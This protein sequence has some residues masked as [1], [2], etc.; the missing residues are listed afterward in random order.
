MNIHG[1]DINIE[2]PKG[3]RR[4]GI[5]A[6]GKRWTGPALPCAYGEI[7]GT[8]AKDGDRVDAY[9]G[10]DRSSRKVFVIDQLKADTGK[11]DEAKVMLGFPSKAAALAD[12]RKSFSDGKADRRI[13]AVTEMSIDRFQDWLKS[14][15]TTKRA[16]VQSFAAG[17]KVMPLIKSG[18]RAAISENI[19]EMS[20]THPH[21]QAVAAALSTARRYGKKAGGRVGY[22]WGGSP[23]SWGNSGPSPWDMPSGLAVN[24]AQAQTATPQAAPGYSPPSMPTYSAP[25]MPAYAPS[26]PMPFQPNPFSQL[27]SMAP[28]QTA[29]PISAPPAPTPAPAAIPQAEPAPAP[30][31]PVSAIGMGG[32]TPSMMGMGRR[33]GGRVGYADGRA[34]LPD[35]WRTTAPY[36][37]APQSAPATFA[38]SLDIARTA[39]AGALAGFLAQ[40]IRDAAIRGPS[41][42]HAVVDDPA[43]KNEGYLGFAAGGMA[44]GHPYGMRGKH[45]PGMPPHMGMPGLGMGAPRMGFAEGGMPWTGEMDSPVEAPRGTLAPIYDWLEDAS[46]RARADLSREHHPLDIMLNPEARRFLGGLGAGYGFDLP[47]SAA[48]VA[49]KGIDYVRGQPEATDVRPEDVGNVA[50]LAAG[51][52]LKG[53]GAVASA[54]KPYAIPALAGLA[55]LAAPTS[56]GSPDAS[57]KEARNAEINKLQAEI[58]KQAENVVRAQKEIGAAKFRGIGEEAGMARQKA[59]EEAARPF[60]DVIA[61]AQDRI[62]ELRAANDEGQNALTRAEQ[63]ADKARREEMGR[64]IPFKQTPVGEQWEKAGPLAPAMVGAG[65]SMLGRLGHGLKSWKLPI[66]EGTLGGALSTNIP[67]AWDAFFSPVANPKR[68]GYQTYGEELKL[69]EHP[70]A[71][72]WLD[73]AKSLPELN[74]VREAAQKEFFDPWK[75]GERMA[76]GAGEGLSGAGAGLASVM[77][78]ERAGRAAKS[79]FGSRLR[80]TTAASTRMPSQEARELPNSLGTATP[81]ALP[82]PAI[83]QSRMLPSPS[84]SPMPLVERQSPALAIVPSPAAPTAPARPEWASNPPTGVKLKK[85]YH[86]DA[87]LNQPRHETGTFGE[88]PK[89]SAPRS[90]ASKANGSRTQKGDFEE[91]APGVPK[92]STKEFDPEDPINRGMKRGGGVDGALAV[93]R[94]YANG[95]KVTVGPVVGATGGRADKLPVDVPAGSFVIP[96]DVVSYFG[97][98]NS[99]AGFQKLEKMFGR[100]HKATGGGVVPIAISHGEFVVSPEAVAKAG[101]GDVNQGH[102]V[103]DQLVLKARREHIKSLQQ[104]PPP[105]A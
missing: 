37:P 13:G 48:R 54:A 22:A 53:L 90:T 61:R 103:L 42:G 1:L 83:P 36:D 38:D 64:G 30:Q 89:Y 105:A 8:R 10:P 79:L 18:S 12:Y 56:A 19:R 27:M 52:A 21:D 45:N 72:E 78:L 62:R 29:A 84:Q 15:D 104:L 68:T 16:S 65:L 32:G 70:R 71:Q 51:P 82:S 2:T 55:G 40:A 6:D 17:G 58:A 43:R 93:A 97:E 25:Q 20:R 95:G 98:N 69:A 35:D 73:Y 47:A 4:T 74:P 11:Y 33:Q 50:Q 86:W 63:R 23:G 9:I 101:G 46:S 91:M 3:S 24:Q 39:P 92:K 34:V 81:E 88:T 57:P 96:S 5:G 7:K 87:N 75:A 85:G 102:R 31:L 28:Q 41:R 76:F 59:M 94:R 14:G 99:G 44:G 49:S 26:Q 60:N 66:A 80:D 67:T 100:S 77:G